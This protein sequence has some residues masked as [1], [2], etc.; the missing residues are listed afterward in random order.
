MAD[1]RDE[2]VIIPLG[3]E[4]LRTSRREVETGRVRVRTLV[5]THEQMVREELTRTDVEIERVPVEI[6]VGSMPAQ[7][8][9]G[10]VTIIPVVEEV[11]FVRK[12]LVVT[13][14]I[15]LRRRIST[16][17]VEQPVTVRTQRAVVE[18][19]GLEGDALQLS[20]RE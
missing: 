11:L 5:E 14:E 19:E 16:E 12:A 18:R 9:E 13:E 7:R 15:R 6:E 8:T 20:S 3:R 10:D 2:T 4:T 17:K 1:D